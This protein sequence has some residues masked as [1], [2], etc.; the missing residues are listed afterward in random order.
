[1][2]QSKNYSIND[3]SDSRRSLD[4]PTQATDPPRNLTSEYH[5]SDNS[6]EVKWTPATLYGSNKIREQLI[7]FQQ[8][9]SKSHIPVS[10]VMFAGVKAKG[11]SYRLKN[12][13]SGGLYRVW[14]E[15]KTHFDIVNSEIINLTVPSI[16]WPEPESY[17]P[18]T[19]KSKSKPYQIVPVTPKPKP[20]PAH[21]S[22][23]PSTS[24]KHHDTTTSKH[25]YFGITL[26]KILIL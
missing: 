18:P 20:K 1:M 15:T 17:T 13:H 11:N 23:E 19:P 22:S 6:I 16:I 10:C 8:I 24:N 14:I 26:K 4:S 3:D 2:R 9:D 21:V 5:E 7:Y 12:L 25:P